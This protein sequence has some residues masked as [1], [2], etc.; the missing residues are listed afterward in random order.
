MLVECA[1][2]FG[3]RNGIVVDCRAGLRPG[4]VG[5]VLNGFQCEV[6]EAPEG[7]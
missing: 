3:T 4:V 6:F 1:V 7:R 5:H 2:R